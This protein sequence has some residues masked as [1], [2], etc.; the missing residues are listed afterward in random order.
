MTRTAVMLFTRDLRVHDHPALT[1]A[2]REAERVVPLFVLDDAILDRAAPNRVAFLRASLEDLRASLVARGGSL[3]VRRGDLLGEVRQVCVDVG[4]TSLHVT[5]D[6]SRYAQERE[7]DLRALARELGASFTAHPGVTVVAPGEL[8]PSSGDH[9]EVFGAYWRRWRD[10]PRREVLPAPE[11]VVLPDGLASARIPALADLVDGDP[12]A[13]LP[14]G[15]EAAGRERLDAWFADGIADYDRLR[16]DLTA[17]ATSRL[18]P[19]LHL[20]TVSANEV[21]SRIDLRR[22]GH[23]PFL[24]QLCWRD[25][26]HQLLAARP[27]LTDR[28]LRPRDDR[29]VDDPELVEAWRA[30]RTGYPVVDAGMRQLV[31]EGFIHNRARMIVASFLTKHL[32]VDW[33]VGAAHF[34]RWLVDGDV[35]SNTSQWQ[36]VAGTG[37]DSRPNRVL[38]PWLQSRRYGAAGYIRRWVPELT[39]LDDVAIHEPYA[40]GT[41]DVGGYPRPMVDHEEA[42]RRFLGARGRA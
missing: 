22:R 27:D 39:H 10:H 21:A 37:T 32:Y 13:Q 1:A 40:E 42:R 3:V 12:S 17:D 2:C 5:A 18:S 4:A 35:A 15:G 34:D 23:E 6:V 9:Y 31:A 28:D 11:R 38:N 24:R 20:G 30:G 14:R 25:H 29:W 41:A 26:A 7:A 33:R 16:D 36:W 8:A 19:H